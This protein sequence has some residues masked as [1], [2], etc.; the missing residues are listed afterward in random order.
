MVDS[1]LG[2]FVFNCT[3]PP[4]RIFDISIKKLDFILLYEEFSLFSTPTSG[5]VKS[6]SD[7]FI[8]MKI[9]GFCVPYISDHFNVASTK[10]TYK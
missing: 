2:L 9:I 4:L 3:P 10:R 8:L 5:I 1:K 6:V 7:G